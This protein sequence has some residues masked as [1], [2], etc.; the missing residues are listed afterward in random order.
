MASTKPSKQLSQAQIERFL[1][2]ADAQGHRR[3][4]SWI[5]HSEH[6]CA[7][8]E[9]VHDPLL[10]SIEKITGKRAKFIQR[11]LIAPAQPQGGPP[12]D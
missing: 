5:T 3:P 8:R 7:L 1:D 11:N 4:C 12:S 2:A 10:K 9:E 6:Y